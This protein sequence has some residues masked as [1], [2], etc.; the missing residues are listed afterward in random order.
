MVGVLAITTATAPHPPGVAV[1]L[2]DADGFLSV[3]CTTGRRES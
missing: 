1:P 3:V 2:S